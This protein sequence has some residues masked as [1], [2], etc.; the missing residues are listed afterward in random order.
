TEVEASEWKKTLVKAEQDDKAYLEELKAKGIDPAAYGQLK[1]QLTQ[2]QSLEKSLSAKESKLQAAADRMAAAWHQTEA[3][4]IERR[5]MRGDL[6]REVSQ[7]SGRLDFE[8]KAN[9]DVTGWSNAVRDLLNLRSDA[10]L[11]DVPRLSEWIWAADDNA[12]Q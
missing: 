6:L 10:F 1:A 5:T 2:Q 4:L 11:E 12:T 8:L 7:R 9:K 3:I